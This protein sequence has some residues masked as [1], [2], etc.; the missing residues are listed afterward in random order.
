VVI[1]A[2]RPRLKFSGFTPYLDKFQKLES[3]WFYS[4]FRSVSDVDNGNAQS[5]HFC[6]GAHNPINM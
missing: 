2:L 5:S 3:Q 1:V 6:S 4:I